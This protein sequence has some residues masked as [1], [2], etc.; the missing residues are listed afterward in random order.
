MANS[1]VRPSPNPVFRA[2]ADKEYITMSIAQ[3]YTDDKRV[4]AWLCH[5][6]LRERLSKYSAAA[7]PLAVLGKLEAG[8]LAQARAG[9][10][11]ALNDFVEDSM[12][13]PQE[14]V[15]EID[16]NLAK[17]GLPGMSV[18]RY[19]YGKRLQKI[20]SRGSVRDDAEYYMLKGIVVD[21]SLH[22]E[23]SQRS[24]IDAL[25]ETYEGRIRP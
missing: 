6:V 1:T 25:L 18:L 14:L 23:A 15:S 20:L 13:W 12:N 19:R 17:E 10:K 4:F 8:S 24:S 9:L 11:M 22:L 21:Q 7:H 2:N 16:R 5:T 3:Q